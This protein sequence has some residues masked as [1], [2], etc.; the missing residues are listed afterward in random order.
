MHSH[1]I[2]SDSKFTLWQQFSSVHLCTSTKPT[3][4]CQNHFWT[5]TPSWQGRIHKRVTWPIISLTDM[6]AC[7]YK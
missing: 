1:N 7:V 5:E 3:L 2:L 6:Y 4:A